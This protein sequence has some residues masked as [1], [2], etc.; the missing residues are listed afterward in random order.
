[1]KHLFVPY[2]IAVTAKEKGV[3][4]D[5][6]AGYYMF[7]NKPELC[8]FQDENEFSDF[9]EIIIE[10]PLYQQIVDWLNKIGKEKHLNIYLIYDGFDN[11]AL[12]RVDR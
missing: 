1:M 6:F 12:K 3:N 8:I 11:K 2:N 4:Q 5:C 7:E 10:A 9:K